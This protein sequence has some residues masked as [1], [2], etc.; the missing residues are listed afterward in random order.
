MG[1]RLGGGG[2]AGADGRA[3]GQGRSRPGDASC[4]NGRTWSRNGRS[5]TA[6]ARAAVSQAPDKRDRAAEAANVA[7]LAAIDARIAEIDKRLAADFPD[8]AA[9]SRPE[10]L[11]VEEVQAQLRA[12][13]ALVLFLDTPGVEANPEETFVWV[14]TKTDMRWV[15]SDL[16]TPALTREV[17]ALRCGLDAAA[18]EGERRSQVCRAS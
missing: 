17:A 10:P 6:C 12:D 2:I 13:E 16:G 11:S 1:A 8:Y 7:R 15:R 9:L 14:V 5:W 3:R 4:A 18:W